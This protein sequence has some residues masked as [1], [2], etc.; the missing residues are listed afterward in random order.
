MHSAMVK[1]EPPRARRQASLVLLSRG[2]SKLYK[3]GKG[4]NIVGDIYLVCTCVVSSTRIRIVVVR[5]NT[6]LVSLLTATHTDHIYS[7]PLT[8][9]PTHTYAYSTHTHTHTHTHVFLFHYLLPKVLLP[10]ITPFR[11]SQPVAGCLVFLRF[12][13]SISTR[14]TNTEMEQDGENK[15][16]RR[17]HPSDVTKWGEEQDSRHVRMGLRIPRSGLA[18]KGGG[19]GI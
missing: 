14:R 16:E 17:R 18:G 4:S 10:T 15:R 11:H 6:H 12:Q 9:T 3:I 19:E 5:S 13:G 2:N 7:L 8:Q 1:Q